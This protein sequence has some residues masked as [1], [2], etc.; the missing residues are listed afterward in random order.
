M[1]DAKPVE[2]KVDAVAKAADAAVALTSP[3]SAPVATAK[4]GGW[5]VRQ[6]RLMFIAAG[7]AVG[8][9]GAVYSYKFFT[10]DPGKATAQQNPPAVAQSKPEEP[11]NPT[12]PT[13]DFNRRTMGHEPVL[14]LGVPTIKAPDTKDTKPAPVPALD[15]EIPDIKPPV[16]GTKDTKPAPAPMLDL[17]I[18]DIKPPVVPDSKD[19][20]PPVLI[21]PPSGVDAKNTKPP[22]PEPDVFKAPGELP[23][24]VTD[25]KG[26]KDAA[27]VI[28]IGGTDPMPPM[29]PKKIDDQP[30]IP[31]I[32]LDI[33]PP[34]P[35]PMK[36]GDTTI[37]KIDLDTPPP[38]PMR[39]DDPP[40]VSPPK[41]GPSPMNIDPPAI[42]PR[43][44]KVPD[45]PTIEA[46]TIKSPM[47]GDP[48][49]PPLIGSKGANKDN[50]DEDWHTKLDDSFVQIS[51]EYFKSPD[52]AA[53]LEAYN[54]DRRKPGERI[55]RVPPPWVLEEQ[56]PNLIG[57]KS[58][59][60]EP[61]GAASPKPEPP[62]PTP[63]GERPAP[64]PAPVAGNNE[65]RVT[66][67]AGETIR[68]I[69]RKLYGDA[70]AWQ[71]LWKLN[72]DLDP[73][74]PIPSGTALRLDK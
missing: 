46:P 50:Y 3:A 53:A 39:T 36:M 56:F 9:A 21:I 55:I 61:K 10:A 8:I 4:A 44:D 67:P 7:A 23:T 2:N 59:K 5:A 40:L 16:P 22:V 14:D 11:A 64:P 68:E 33:P 65:Y 32:D 57:T 27:P 35:T 69:A 25:K 37:P 49:P 54:K 20:K 47:I 45:V 43:T 48:P 72:P 73:T 1:S 41:I 74:L 15:L 52:Y 13:P 17:E 19:T 60:P 26:T 62:A 58:D 12:A 31:K 63:P 42:S 70:N 51:K 6:K 29:P 28:R 18:P 38:K 24:T 30:P 34:P 66:A 71:K